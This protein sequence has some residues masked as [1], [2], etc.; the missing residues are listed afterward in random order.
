MRGFI[1]KSLLDS[2]LSASGI[3]GGRMGE[4]TGGEIDFLD[5]LNA[6]FGGKARVW[7][8]DWVAEG[9][10]GGG[11]GGGRVG[12]EGEVE[13]NSR[14]RSFGLSEGEAEPS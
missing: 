10:G 11:G 14:K 6:S 1:P 9:G 12:G 2:S 4:G 7:S 8:G 5:L 13:S 3:G